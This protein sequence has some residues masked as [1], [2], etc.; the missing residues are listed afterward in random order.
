MGN[1]SISSGESVDDLGVPWIRPRAASDSATRHNKATHRS[2]KD[3]IPSSG[4]PSSG[5][6]SSGS[7]GG[8]NSRSGSRDGSSF[9]SRG[10]S[11]SDDSPRTST[12]GS[13][14]KSS[15]VN[16]RRGFNYQRHKRVQKLISGCKISAAFMMINSGLL[17]FG[18]VTKQS[19][20]HFF[21]LLKFYQLWYSTLV[22]S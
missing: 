17:I 22:P 19:S 20:L 7:G 10:S 2:S 14:V 11:A 1:S 15:L 5:I 4:I 6:P 18:G 8:R 13:L 3:K 21:F 12:K 9:N 16:P